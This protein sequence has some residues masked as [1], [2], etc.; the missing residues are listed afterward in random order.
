MTGEDEQGDKTPVLE[1]VSVNVGQKTLTATTV[2]FECNLDL[3]EAVSM[4]LEAYF[5]YSSTEAMNGS[6]VKVVK[7]KTGAQDLKLTGLVF[8]K[9]Y[10]YE[11][12]LEMFGA[13][14]N[15]VKNSFSTQNITIEMKPAE[16]NANVLSLG[17]TLKGCGE[18]IHGG[19]GSGSFRY[20]NCSVSEGAC[21]CNRIC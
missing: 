15:K 4:P 19:D 13:E 12:F 20:S 3:G 7:L 6:D 14:Y 2:V 16:Q 17:G 21:F 18:V 8:G 9:T 10:Y 5:R 11:I 1:T